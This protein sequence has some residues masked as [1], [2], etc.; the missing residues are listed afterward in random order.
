[1]PVKAGSVKKHASGMFDVSGDLGR[2]DD[3]PLKKAFPHPIKNSGGELRSS[4][5]FGSGIGEIG[6]IGEKNSNGGVTAR[7]NTSPAL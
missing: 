7:S 5:V 1:M 2:R 3:L 4:K 6:K